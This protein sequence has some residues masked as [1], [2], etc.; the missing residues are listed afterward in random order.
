[1]RGFL[2]VAAIGSTLVI[3]GCATSSTAT[4]VVGPTPTPATPGTPIAQPTPT[5]A[6]ATSPLS[7]AHTPTATVTPTVRT[8]ATPTPA[9]V[10]GQSRSHPAS[11]G[12]SLTF[13]G[14]ELL[15]GDYEAR[16]TLIEVVRGEEAWRRIREA[17]QFNG[18]PRAGFEYILA[19]VKFEYLQGA[20]D[21]QYDLNRVKFT[22]VSKDGKDYETVIVVEPEP[23]LQ[24]NLY[25]GASHEGWAAFQVE[26]I[27]AM[28]LLTFGRDFRGSSGVWWQL[29]K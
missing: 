21:R 18:P 25:P 10:P 12:T 11:I 3:L 28:P 15:L 1:M 7:P 22:A 29:F 24:A 27:D 2:K 23:K 8:A 26:Q 4:P 14:T 17:N 6:T 20:A 16:I 5:V 19:K 9:A 13:Q